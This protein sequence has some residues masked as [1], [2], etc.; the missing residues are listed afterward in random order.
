MV[1]IVWIEVDDRTF[2]T[3]PQKVLHLNENLNFT[4][5][6]KSSMAIDSS[7]DLRLNTSSRAKSW[8]L[9]EHIMFIKHEF[10]NH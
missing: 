8:T 1:L 6:I 7:I 3:I 5:E 9:N 4:H 10:S 2:Q